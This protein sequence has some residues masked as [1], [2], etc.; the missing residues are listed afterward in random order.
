MIDYINI[1]IKYYIKTIIFKFKFLYK[2][3]YII[4]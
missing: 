2:N 1:L 3:N 4:L